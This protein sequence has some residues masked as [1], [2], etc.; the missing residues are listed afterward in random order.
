MTKDAKPTRKPKAK[1]PAP[2]PASGPN[3]MQIH[4]EPEKRERLLADLT[5][6]GLFTNAALM[7]TFS[8]NIAGEIGI[9]EAVQSLRA[10]LADV[11]RGD[12]RC[13]ETMLLAQAAALNAMFAELARRAGANMGQYLDP[14]EKYMRLALK[15]QGQCRATLETL[16]AIKNPPLVFARQANINNGG[17][18][19]VNNG[20]G[21]PAT[22]SSETSTRPSA[23]AGKLQSEPSKLLEASDVERLDTG[24]PRA[25]G[26]A[27]QDVE[28]VGALNRPDDGGR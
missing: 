13:V 20:P 23:H 25:A 6:E 24:A 3:V 21:A 27:H 22:P 14:A 5:T 8:A 1:A 26:A 7:K 15:A 9:T 16:A 11:N 17:Q 19:Q 28:T 2:A 10:S 4:G 18:Q 12:L